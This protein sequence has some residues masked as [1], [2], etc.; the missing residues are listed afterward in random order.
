MCFSHQESKNSG[1]LLGRDKEKY[2]LERFQVARL[3]KIMWVARGKK[4]KQ[5][6]VQN[7]QKCKYLY[8]L[9]IKIKIRNLTLAVTN[10]NKNLY[11]AIIIEL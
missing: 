11:H 2:G 4:I 5:E 10:Y 6:L 9:D 8:A 3:K 7:L 1:K